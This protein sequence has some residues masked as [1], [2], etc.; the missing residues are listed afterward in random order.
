MKWLSWTVLMTIVGVGLVLINPLFSISVA[1]G[2]ILGTLLWIGMMVKSL[3]DVLLSE[4]LKQTPA[5]KAYQEYLVEKK[6]KDQQ[7][8][9]S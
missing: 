9:N 2:L 6:H 4:E 3:H 5:D 8:N 7:L 1:F